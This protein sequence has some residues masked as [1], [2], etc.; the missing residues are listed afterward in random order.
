MDSN[1]PSG[2]GRGNTQALFSS[3]QRCLRC[4]DLSGTLG[5]SHCMGRCVYLRLDQITPDRFSKPVVPV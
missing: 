5:L 2:G 3:Q 4:T 1:G